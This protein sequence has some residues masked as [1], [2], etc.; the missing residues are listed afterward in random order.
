MNEAALLNLLSRRFHN[1]SVYT[2]AGDILISLNPYKPVGLNKEGPSLSQITKKAL[3][4][5]ATN[6]AS[7]SLLINGESGAG[8]TEAAKAVMKCLLSLSKGRDVQQL[9]EDSNVLLEAFGN[10]C[11]T[12]N[13]NSSRFGKYVKFHYDETLQISKLIL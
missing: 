8:K 7:Q 9:I 4:S 12:K 10:A 1:D 13:H 6:R 2:L 5:L 11:T 3:E